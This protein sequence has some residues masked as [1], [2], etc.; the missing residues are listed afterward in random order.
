VLGAAIL[1]SAVAFSVLITFFVSRILS[2]TVL[3]G[4]PASF[5]L[6]L[7]PYRLP[8][9][10]KIMIRS[11]FDRTLKILGRAVLVAVPAGIII[12]LCS[13][14][15]FGGRTVLEIFASVL[16]PFAKILGLDGNVLCGFI[17]SLPAN[18]IALPIMAMGY[19]GG[20]LSEL[21]SLS[22]T[23]A[24]FSSN[25]FTAKNA[26]CT[27]IFFLFHWPCATTIITV[28]KETKS[29][30]WTALSILVPLLTGLSLCLSVN[31]VSKLLL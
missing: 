23:A 22:E 21:G 9:F 24:L 20:T 27:I 3:K 28:W 11:V 6:E 31:I 18:E 2:K 14:L 10:G 30:K 17:L 16:N 15:S 1:T 19:S 4:I 8:K 12:W 25:G 7:P 13:Y 26:L 29:A 5:T